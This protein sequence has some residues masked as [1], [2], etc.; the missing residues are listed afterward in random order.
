MNS[1]TQPQFR[2][3]YKSTLLPTSIL[4]L[5]NAIA[6]YFG[7]HIGYFGDVG[8]F[9]GFKTHNEHLQRTAGAFCFLISAVNA[10]P[11]IL[12]NGDDMIIF[13]LL[14]N[15]FVCTHYILEGTIFRGM[16]IEI[17]LVMSLFMVLNLFWSYK[18]FKHKQTIQELQSPK[19]Q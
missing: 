14:T 19:K 8:T 1:I 3:Y 2:R 16:R 7:T 6:L 15:I 12:K 5:V 10:A 17:L 9:Y 11:L 4:F 18:D 13:S